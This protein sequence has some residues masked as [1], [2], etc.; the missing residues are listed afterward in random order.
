[1]AYFFIYGSSF[2]LSSV[3]AALHYSRGSWIAYQVFLTMFSILASLLDIALL[4]CFI[5]VLSNF[6][7]LIGL[8]T[9]AGFTPL[10][11]PLVTNAALRKY[12]WN[13][14]CDGFDGTVY[15]AAVHYNQEGLSQAQF[16][17]PS[18]AKNGNYGNHR[19]GCTNSPRSGR[20]GIRSILQL[21]PRR[22][23]CE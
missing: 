19:R 7:F 23:Q 10:W 8:A 11:V 20:D 9:I 13:N 12:H 6:L 17:P 3:A 14:D 22:V 15:L 5:E 16:Q 1:M 21:S 18:A 2:P 4:F